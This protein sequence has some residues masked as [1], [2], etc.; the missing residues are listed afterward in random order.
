MISITL[1]QDVV[2]YGIIGLL[3][4]MSFLS[5]FF[6]IERLLFYRALKVE[7]Y[8]YKEALEMDVSNHIHII[9]SFGSNA[10]YIGLLGTVFGIILT[11]YTMGLSG[12]IDVKHI[13]SSLALALKATAMGLVVAI[14]AIF[15]YNHLVRKIEKI[16]VQWDLAHK[17]PKRAA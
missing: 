6:W 15:L 1:L 5:F 4:I 10:P 14:P 9:S 16:L 12:E 7:T 2:D 8:Q 3:G 11:F 13:M 17:E